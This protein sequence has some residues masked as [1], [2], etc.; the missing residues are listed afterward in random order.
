MHLYLIIFI[1]LGFVP[2]TSLQVAIADSIVDQIQDCISKLIP[3]WIEK[4]PTKK[5]E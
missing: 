2:S 4:D 5:V 1:T 3:I